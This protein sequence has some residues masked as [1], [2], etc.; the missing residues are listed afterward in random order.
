MKYIFSTPLEDT[1]AP[2][3]SNKTEAKLQATRAISRM[4]KQVGRDKVIQLYERG[5]AEG[6][7]QYVTNQEAEDL[8]QHP[9]TF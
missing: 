2:H 1:F 5:E 7:F 8:L 6:C 4:I 3:K 9:H